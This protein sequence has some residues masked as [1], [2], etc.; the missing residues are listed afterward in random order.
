ML[1]SGDIHV[2]RHHDYG[3]A[4]LGYPLHE[5]VISPMHDKIIPSLDV[6]HSARK[7]SETAKNVF[8]KVDATKEKLVVTWVD[9][10]GL[11]RYT[12]EVEAAALS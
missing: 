12:K 9:M 10:N 6:K 5:Y 4:S 8:L 11:K 3:S 2:C 7:W 1:V